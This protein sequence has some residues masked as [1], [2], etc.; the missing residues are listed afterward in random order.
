MR[1][2]AAVKPAQRWRPPHSPFCVVRT[3]DDGILAPPCPQAGCHFRWQRR[4][5]RVLP[6]RASRCGSTAAPF[7]AGCEGWPR[8]TGTPCSRQRR[9][10]LH[11]A[12][13]TR[14]LCLAAFIVAA[15]LAGRLILWPRAAD[16]GGCPK[17]GPERSRRLRRG[18]AQ[19]ATG[20][21]KATARRCAAS[22]RRS[23]RAGPSWPPSYPRRQP[24]PAQAPASPPRMRAV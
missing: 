6:T 21:G 19:P 8:E 3:S 9:A 12:G 14:R 24:S 5:S 22:P 20:G 16:A 18:A 1:H 2:P 15:A 11:D 13:H 7:Q 17:A 10:G 4:G 23:G